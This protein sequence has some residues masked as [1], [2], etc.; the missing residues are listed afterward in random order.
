MM[1]VAS[2]TASVAERATLVRDRHPHPGQDRGGLV[3]VPAHPAAAEREPRS[4]PLPQSRNDLALRAPDEDRVG[5]VFQPVEPD[6]LAEPDPFPAFRRR[7][8]HAATRSIS[9]IGTT[10]SSSGT[11]PCPTM[12][13]PSRT[14]AVRPGASSARQ[15][16]GSPTAG[17]SIAHPGSVPS[18]GNRRGRIRS[19][20]GGGLRQEHAEPGPVGD[21]SIPGVDHLGVPG[22]LRIEKRNERGGVDEDAHGPDASSR[23]RACASASSATPER[24]RPLK[25]ACATSELRHVRG[26]PPR[27]VPGDALAH[28]LHNRAFFHP[29]LG[30]ERPC[31]LFGQPDPGS[32]HAIMMV[33]RLV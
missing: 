17:H 31:L 21:R 24:K 14:K 26:A 25:S 33:N 29:R 16:S 12:R 20:R 10:T 3:P 9:T 19:R 4:Q 6:A 32:Y 30:L 1:R 27:Q 2:P 7:P 22:L 18:P 15:S 13:S 8:L 11:L 28:Q 23:W 5:R